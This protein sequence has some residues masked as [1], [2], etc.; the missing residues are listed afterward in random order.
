MTARRMSQ[1]AAADWQMRARR[2]HAILDSPSPSTIDPGRQ[3]RNFSMMPPIR[4]VLGEDNLLAREGIAR[5]LERSDEIELIGAY[6][7][8]VGLRAAV[9][10]QLP[11]V[12]LTDIRMAPD[13]EDE[14]IRLAAELRASHPEIGVVVLSVDADA[15]HALTLFEEGSDRRA[16]LLKDRLREAEDLVRAIREVARGGALVDPRIVDELLD[17]RPPTKLDEL[18]DRE[19]EVLAL[20]AHGRS[21][22][23]IAEELVITKRAVEHH[24]N[25]IFAKL[26]LRDDAHVNRRVR[27]TLMYL[28]EDGR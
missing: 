1:A 26:D 17:M 23:A 10:R 9:E 22:A 8:V 4:V 27:A 19:R 28:A 5:L 3:E 12:V 13:H 14:G 11:D 6:D 24:V 16:Y 15:V 18:T 2:A 20:M 7:D 21:N 25:S